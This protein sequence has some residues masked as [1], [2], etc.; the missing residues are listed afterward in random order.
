MNREEASAE[1]ANT[2]ALWSVGYLRA[3]DVVRAACDALVAGMDGDAL[4]M[5]AAV[6]YRNADEEVPEFLEA[7]LH[8]LALDYRSP[9]SRNGQAAAVKVLAARVLAGA[10]PPRELAFWAHGTI[11]HDQLPLA[12]RLVELDDVYDTVGYDDQPLDEVDADVVAEA[13]RIVD[14]A[15]PTAAPQNV[16]GT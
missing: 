16:D 11:G 12:E 14:G 7:R 2:A 10:L 3:A 15:P 13:R 9:R 8:E 6:P 5:L 1:L 4:R